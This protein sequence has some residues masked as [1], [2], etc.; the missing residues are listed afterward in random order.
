MCVWC[1]EGVGGGVRQ[2][3]QGRHNA[4]AHSV[5]VLP[6]FP[7]LSPQRASTAEEDDD[8][9]A[10]PPIPTPKEGAEFEVSFA[11]IQ[12][13]RLVAENRKLEAALGT[14]MKQRLQTELRGTRDSVT[15]L[16]KVRPPPLRKTC[17]ARAVVLGDC[18][19]HEYQLDGSTGGVVSAVQL[20]HR[21]ATVVCPCT[22]KSS[23]LFHLL[24]DAVVPP[25]H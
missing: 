5:S 24:G 9:E 23:F 11:K 22:R 2:C 10:L 16:S 19:S 25:S 1:W 13:E 3:V 12:I 7:H 15:M 14:E 20:C 8:D 18:T 4:D 21:A 6:C 17:H